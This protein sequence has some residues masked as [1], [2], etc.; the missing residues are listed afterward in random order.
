LEALVSFNDDQLI[1]DGPVRV[2][3][4]DGRIRAYGSMLTWFVFLPPFPRTPT[5]VQFST[6]FNPN[7]AGAKLF[8]A[9]TPAGGV[10]VDG[11]PDAVPATSFSRW[12]QLAT[13]SGSLI[14]VGDYSEVGGS[15]KNFYLDDAAAAD[16]T[17]EP[18]HYGDTGA[19]IDN[20]SNG[21]TFNFNYYFLPGS[22]PNVGAQ[23]EDYFDQP[24]ASS[25]EL[26][27]DR[28]KVYLPMVMR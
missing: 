22:Q 1:K 12:W 6:D 9:V 18:G 27:D 14:Q 25:V 15:P 3:M 8:N 5:F 13:T 11:S 24:L 4:R 16:P 26:H 28:E 20:P 23:Y 10:T 21:F 19:R 2:I 17:G 7:A